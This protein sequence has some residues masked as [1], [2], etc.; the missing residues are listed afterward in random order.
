MELLRILFSWKILLLPKN[1]SS[2]IRMSLD[3]SLVHMLRSA[4]APFTA[5][6]APA[7]HFWVSMLVRS[8][9]ATRSTTLRLTTS[10]STDC[11]RNSL[12]TRTS[13]TWSSFSVCQLRIP[14]CNGW[15]TSSR[16]PSLVPSAS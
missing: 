5:S 12:Q 4:A 9:L 2:M 13:S 16:A 10:F 8:V 11:P 15:R 1:L 3:R 7:L 14:V 6:W